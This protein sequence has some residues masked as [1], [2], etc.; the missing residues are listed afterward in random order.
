MLTVAS[1]QSDSSVTS[2]ED[3]CS[4]L[5][6]DNAFPVSLRILA[7]ANSG[8]CLSVKVCLRFSPFDITDR[9]TTVNLPN[10]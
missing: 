4:F 3:M 2:L 8:Q 1:P 10:I 6:A 9:L 7:T 5:T